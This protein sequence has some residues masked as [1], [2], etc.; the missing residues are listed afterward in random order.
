[1][2][3]DTADQDGLA[4]A[5]ADAIDDGIAA[6][7][8][9]TYPTRRVAGAT[10]TATGNRKQTAVVDFA[11]TDTPRAVVVQTAPDEPELRREAALTRSIGTRTPVPVPDVITGGSIPG[12]GYLVSERAPG[13]DLHRRFVGLNSRSRA[14]V[15]RSFGRFLAHLHGAFA[16]A[17]Y[18]SVVF[19]AAEGCDAVDD[20]GVDPDAAVDGEIG[21][22]TGAV[23][24]ADVLDTADPGTLLSAE[25]A[26]ATAGTERAGTTWQS[27]FT[28]Y[29]VEGIDALPSTF[30]DVRPTIQA[31][32]EDAFD[33]LPR[34][35]P[36]RLYPWDL[37]PGN[38]LVADSEL[39]AVLDWGQPL[40]ADPGLAV[41]KA[42]HLVCDWY[43][44]DSEQLR[45]AF[46]A[47]Y[48]AERPLPE[49]PEEY[50]LI[51]VVRSAVDAAGEVTRPRYPERTG[52]EAVA[53][54][55]RRIH[56]VLDG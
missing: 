35:P 26:A 32:V 46:R 36:A 23:G 56:A 51:A 24:W 45:H 11:D 39:S 37:R 48:R 21:A 34:A 16:F 5:E 40:A 18:G 14:R 13:D 2:S 1:M 47:G 12:G 27:W 54:H 7:L 50:R 15:A 43:V 33:D 9:R 10:P 41:A 6:V 25:R 19:D 4:D 42:E 55:K 31:S 44:E 22:A 52:A 17:G 53:F 49:V 28:Q 8:S 20:G 3:D 38:A 30:D 29:A